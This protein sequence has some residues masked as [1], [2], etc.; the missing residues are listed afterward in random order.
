MDDKVKRKVE[1]EINKLLQTLE[2]GVISLV[3]DKKGVQIYL[4]GREVASI[5]EGV[6]VFNR[7]LKEKEIKECCEKEESEGGMRFD[8]RICYVGVGEDVKRI[9]ATLPSQWYSVIQDSDGDFFITNSEN[10]KYLIDLFFELKKLKEL[11]LK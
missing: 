9:L 1:W 11:G 2:S 8:G 4:N 7:A 10:R 6:S 5:S 3:K